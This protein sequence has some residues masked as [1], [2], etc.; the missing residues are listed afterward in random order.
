[1]IKIV[2]DILKVFHDNEL[3][4]EGVELIGSWCF[5]LY[6]KHCNVEKYPLKT[7]DIDF[8]IPFPYKGKNKIDLID[9]LENIGFRTGFNNDGSFYLRNAEIKIEF[10]SP[11]RGRGSS[12]AFYIKNL[13]KFAKKQVRTSN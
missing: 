1:M 4:N 8:L 6:Q 7:V 11:E 3:W 12:K 10:L 13:G 5:E 2:K 9:K